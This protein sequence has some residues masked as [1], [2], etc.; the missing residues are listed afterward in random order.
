MTRRSELRIFD[1]PYQ[2][3]VRLLYHFY[4]L[5]D[6]PVICAIQVLAG[7]FIKIITAT[8]NF[9][10]NLCFA[11]FALE[12]QNSIELKFHSF[13]SAAMALRIFNFKPSSFS[14]PFI[15]AEIIS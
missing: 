5:S 8:C 12:V 10:L 15:T 9:Y 3:F 14:S 7:T 11:R 1:L 13:S 6:D 4:K 2:P